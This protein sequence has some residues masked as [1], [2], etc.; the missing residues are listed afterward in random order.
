ML[1][2]AGYDVIELLY[3]GTRSLVYRAKRRVDSRSFILKTLTAQ[4]PTLDAIATLKHEYEILSSTNI[5]GTIK[6]VEWRASAPA[7]VLENY[8][9]LSLTDF[10]KER[11]A[12]PL[13]V[14]LPVA[15][16]LTE[17]LGH[18]HQQQLIH[19]DIKP[20]NILINPDTKDVRLI[21]FGLAS[22]LTKNAP[23]NGAIYVNLKGRQ[24]AGTYA[25]M[26]PE[27]TGRMNRTVDY[28]SDLYSLGVTFYQML[29]GSLPFE[30]NDALA[31]VHCHIAKAP[32]PLKAANPKVPE[33][34]SQIIAK[35]LAK[36]AEARYQ[37]AEGLNADLKRCLEQLAANGKISSF[38]LGSQDSSGQFQIPQRLYGRESE[39]QILLDTFER[40][41]QGSRELMLVSGYSGIG[42]S[43]LVNE[44]HK[45]IVRQRGYFITGKFDQLKRNI[46][47]ASL[48]QAFQD[49]IRQL[50]SEGETE[51]DRWRQRLQTCLGSSGQVLVDV[52]PELALIVGPQPPLAAVTSAESQARFNQTFQKMVRVFAQPAHPLV[53]F[54][55]DLQWVDRASLD[56]I[57]QIFTDVETQHALIIGAYRDNEVGPDH[58]LMLILEQLHRQQTTIS[59]IV[60]KPLQPGHV[61]QLVADTLIAHRTAVEPLSSLIFQKTAGN[62]FFTRS[63]FNAL[64]RD[65]QLTFSFTESSWQWD[66]AQLQEVSL[67]DNVVV[68]MMGRIYQLPEPVQQLLTLAACIGDRF[69]LSV[70]SVVSKQSPTEAARAL[71]P[72][73]AA[74]LIVPL[75]ENYQIPMLLE[76]KDL[77]EDLSPEV[78]ENIRYKFVHDRV[79]EAAYRLLPDEMRDRTHWQIGNLRLQQITLQGEQTDP[80]VIEETLEENIFEI[81][82]PLNR[83]KALA[84][85]DAERYQMADLNWLAGRKAKSAN[86]HESALAYF[87]TGVSLLLD[88]AWETHYE[89]TFALYRDVSECAYLCGHFER[90]EQLFEQAIAQAASAIDRATIQLIRIVLYD[91]QGKFTENLSVGGE[92]LRNLGLSWP[93]TTN[94]TA[95]ILKKEQIV[96]QRLLAE[97]ADISRLVDQPEMTDATARICMQLLVSMTGPAYF[98]D[99]TLVTLITLKMSVLSLRYGNSQWAAQGYVFW[100]AMLSAA[101][102]DY[103]TAY[104]FGKVGL[105]L[106][107]RYSNYNESKTLNSYVGFISHWHVPLEK[108]I[109]L[110]RRGYLAGVEIG[111]VFTGYVAHVLSLHLILM[112]AELSEIKAEVSLLSAYLH[113]SQNQVFAQQM[114]AYLYCIS[115]YQTGTFSHRN[116]DLRDFDEGR[117]RQL[118]Q[119]N[120]YFTGVATLLLLKVIYHFLF[121]QYEKALALCEENEQFIVFVAGLAAEPEHV[122]YHSL[123]LAALYN[124]AS[125]SQQR[126]YWA[127]LEQHLIRLK[128]WAKSCEANYQHKY[129]LVAAEMARL[130]HQPSDALDYYDQAITSAQT[131][132]FI[133]NMA[134]AN[135]KAAQFWR[136]RGNNNVAITYARSAYHAYK[137]WGSTAKANAI[138]AHYPGLLITSAPRAI[139]LDD[140]RFSAADQT[141][142]SASEG[143]ENRLDLTTVMKASQ[144]I[145]SEIRL[146]GL[147]QTLMQIVIENA[148]AQ[149]G[150]LLLRPEGDPS[151]ERPWVVEALSD[152]DGNILTQQ[153]QSTKISEVMPVSMMNYVARTQEAIV[154]SNS[155]TSNTFS[156]DPYIIQHQPKS[157]LCMPIGYRGQLIGMLY[158]ENNLTT[159]AFTPERL[160]VLSLL[161]AQTAISLTNARLYEQMRSLNSN[162]QQEVAR[163]QA[164][165]T[166]LRDSEQRLTQL[167]EG[168]PVGVFVVDAQGQPYYANQVA[169]HI[170]G[171]G[172]YPKVAQN[173]LTETYQAYQTGTSRLY[174][175][176]QLPI[177]QAL[178]G[179]SVTVDDMEVHQGDRIIPLE[180]SS[181][182]IFN[183][184]GD[185]TYAVTAFQDITLRKQAEQQRTEFTRTLEQKVQ[186]RTQEL[187]QTLAVLKATQAELV[188]E[189]ALLR[190]D[191]EASTYDYQ[192]GGSLATDAPTYVVRQADRQLYR[193]LRQQQY[194][195]IFN[196]RQMGKSSLRVQMMKRMRVEGAACVAIDLSVIGNRQTTQEQ[197]YAG[198]M[199]VLASSLNLSQ[200]VDIRAWWKG[201]MLLSPLQRLDEFVRQIVLHKISENIVVF[202]DEVDSVMS[203]DFEADDFFIWLRTC[204]NQRADDSSYQRLTF[205]LLGVASPSQLI[206]DPHRTPFNIGQAIELKGFQL[207]EAHPLLQGLPETVARPQ[208]VLAEVLLW[209]GGQP[210]LS[211]KICQVIRHSKQPIREGEEKAR[212]EELVR[213][214]IISNWETKDDPE[215]LK[216]I[217]DRLLSSP[218]QTRTLLSLYQQLLSDVLVPVD[219]SPEQNELRLSG[220]VTRQAEQLSIANRIYTTV[221]DSRWVARI[222]QSL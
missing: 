166:I 183:A 191:D 91:N 34:L 74:G 117:C 169:Q 137:Q 2:I 124:T 56:L 219:D 70:L 144:A 139:S 8:S 79:Q 42:K 6:A 40:V 213:S 142:L 197:W 180:V 65:K 3:S 35:L 127:T 45:P 26:S 61:Q 143:E 106:T 196:A 168:I 7:L 178:R 5:P 111:D 105:Q 95:A 201:H 184:K 190:T 155:L 217:R 20:S 49:L 48:I 176:D 165:E 188:I 159:S 161:S 121:E 173:S 59:E 179:K 220:L 185:I 50:L 86:A 209:T 23:Q 170:L 31:W 13:S 156:I 200:T 97:H 82:N 206:Q 193:A 73:L 216:T 75:G 51:L 25:Y 167:L 72:A 80:K 57:T 203:L 68:L 104:D 205:V 182:P 27:Q 110:L 207:H 123:V 147:L 99:P 17:T 101:Y 218:V 151:P 77:S 192:V 189:N 212:V 84:T 160:E 4:Y 36:T 10:L 118:F 14:F 94:D 67:T 107:E 96:Y 46:P 109:P 103:K 9:G 120:Q 22:R 214:Q 125:I 172:P 175:T 177:V 164:S 78:L 43:A 66:I 64:Y 112:G 89:R 134:I 92:A 199:Y 130:S 153:I 19:R 85:T 11:G 129:L 152:R 113:K 29:A 202:I 194:C 148:G 140:D 122:F 215:H 90:A 181:T 76:P 62:A 24:P 58:P 39:L 18:I 88:T 16:A 100:G 149:T 71:W 145:A 83:G 37:Q 114:Q 102:Q 162:L 126:T 211:Q 81:V 33:V 132:G 41:S 108:D 15:I 32:I 60:L 131:H 158:L 138:A 163:R 135:E 12:L 198:F 119:D 222:L 171:K 93:Y 146:E 98:T 21:D 141:T 116:N 187:S 87:D 154:L 210:F 38:A 208:S 55:D 44:I 69:D 30:A 128:G 54:L 221:F 157:I 174:P 63:L 186:N 204:F 115:A 47:Y 195:Y 133:Q 150:V 53:I 1:T 52:I 28:R 136:S